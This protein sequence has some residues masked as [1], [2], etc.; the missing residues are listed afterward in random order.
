MKRFTFL[1][2]FCFCLLVVASGCPTN[3]L[4]PAR[5][6]GSVS[7]K[8]QPIKA[9]A[10]AFHSP[11]GIAYPAQLASDG[12]YTATDLPTGDLVITVETESVNKSAQPQGG[13]A[14]RRQGMQ[15]QQPPDGGAA[16]NKAEVYT[17]IPS[18]YANPKTSPL[19]VTLAAGRKVHNIE[20][21]D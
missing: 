15:Q 11:D 14:K 12:T 1:I 3:S 21:T 5:V 19:T 2:L 16:P 18:K 17:K 10:I 4:A 20:L 8:G 6:S 13:D 7:Y 9:G